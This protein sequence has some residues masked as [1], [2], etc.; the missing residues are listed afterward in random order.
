MSSL[1]PNSVPI[2]LRQR[3]RVEDRWLQDRPEQ[4]ATKER[5]LELLLDKYW[6]G[7]ARELKHILLALAE[8]R[9]V[10]LVK[11]EVVNASAREIL[12]YNTFIDQICESNLVKTHGPSCRD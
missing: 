7:V 10:G 8:I 5:L 4:P 12:G 2:S 6:Q 1:P 3:R 11:T 9:D